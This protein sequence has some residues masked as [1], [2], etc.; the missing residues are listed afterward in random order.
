M[1]IEQRFNRLERQNKHM[2]KGMIGMVLAGISLL[3]MAQAAPPKVHDLIRAK[4]I[5]VV[6]ENGQKVISLHSWKHGGWI[7]TYGTKKNTLSILSADDV[8]GGNFVTYNS[9]G[10]D[11]VELSSTKSGNGII[12]TYSAK[13]KGL[14][15][16]T[17]TPEGSGAISTYNSKGKEL[18]SITSTTTDDG[19][20]STYD[21]NGTKLIGITARPSGDGVVI[22]FNRAGKPSKLWPVKYK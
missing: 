7:S 19:S 4:K 15:K 2:K 16:I 6:S 12:S 8:G 13:G 5:E 9:K 14:V 20:I 3:V 18:V 22:Q 10:K 1:T 11:L 21:I 17:A